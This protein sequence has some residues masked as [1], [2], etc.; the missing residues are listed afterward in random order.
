MT[1]TLALIPTQ[2][3]V[4]LSTVDLLIIV[5]YFALVLAIGF[6]LKGQA[7]TSEDYFMAGREMTHGLPG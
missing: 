4:H 3:L 6:Y 2:R 5:F 7:N 1:A